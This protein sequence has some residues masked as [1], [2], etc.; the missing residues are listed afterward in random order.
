MAVH[1]GQADHA[2]SEVA[3][4]SGGIPATQGSRLRRGLGAVAG[5]HLILA[6]D[7][8]GPFVLLAHLQKGSPL[9]EPGDDVST[10]QPV[11]A[12]G[13]SGNSTQP[14][15]HIQIMDSVDR[16]LPGTTHGLP[17]LSPGRPAPT[18]RARSVLPATA[19][20]SSR[21]SRSS[22]RH[23]GM[24][25]RAEAD[26]CDGLPESELNRLGWLTG[27]ATMGAVEQRT[28]PGAA[29]GG[30]MEPVR[31]V[32]Q[33]SFLLPCS[34]AV[35]LPLF[36]PEGERQWVSGWHPEY[37]SGAAD[38]VGAVWRTS[39]GGDTTWITTD[40]DDSRVRYA[41]VSDNG[42]AGLVEVLCS[43]TENGTSVRV[44]YDLTACTTA[45]VDAVHRFTADFDD[46]LEHWRQATAVPS[47]EHRSRASQS[48]TFAGG[49]WSP[50]GRHRSP[51]SARPRAA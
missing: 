13:N 9:V 40:R 37:L 33:G 6:L 44:T 19:T 22:R 45:G 41:R 21:S 36:T 10:G 15:L 1:D 17:R 16:S 46:M 47:R 26:V 2:A 3:V 50:A 18:N 35:A 20:A 14:H 12:C 23:E 7:Q 29:V 25:D 49:R 42:T 24:T 43:P 39:V 4:D 28:P 51:R 38:E 27:R 11:A 31:A 32:R 5:N 30:S 48:T 34:P 8:D